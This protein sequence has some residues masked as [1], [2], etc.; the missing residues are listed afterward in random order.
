[1]AY[2]P[3]VDRQ[4]DAGLPAARPGSTGMSAIAAALAHG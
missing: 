4:P 2:R 1:M 3:A